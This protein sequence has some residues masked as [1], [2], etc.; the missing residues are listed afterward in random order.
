MLSFLFLFFLSCDNF[1]DT[2]P[3]S[4]QSADQYYTNEDEIESAIK[5]L[6]SWLGSPFQGVGF[7]EA[8]L[9]ML[10]FPTGQAKYTTGQQSIMNPDFENLVYWD[11]I[12]V[13]TW[14]SSSF[15]AIEA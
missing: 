11:R 8:P 7:G 13:D 10:E 9:L 3:K 5:G 1:L 4:V 15:Y 2:T 6:Y 14:W 12:Y